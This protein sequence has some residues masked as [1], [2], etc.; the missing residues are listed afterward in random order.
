MG[1]QKNKF[2][3]L[4]NVK[5]ILRGYDQ[6]DTHILLLEVL[7]WLTFLGKNISMYQKTLEDFISFDSTF[8]KWEAYSKIFMTFL[9][10]SAI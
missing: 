6:T 5:M 9:S 10:I 2:Y 7:I 1:N 3:W 8:V 4:I